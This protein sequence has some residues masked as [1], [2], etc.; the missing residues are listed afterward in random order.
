MCPPQLDVGAKVFVL[1]QLVDNKAGRSNVG[2]IV[3]PLKLKV[4]TRDKK[5]HHKLP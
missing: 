2:I 5:I 3:C 4:T 1:Y